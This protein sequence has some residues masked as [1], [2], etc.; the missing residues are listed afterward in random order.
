[1][2]GIWIFSSSYLT[3]EQKRTLTVFI[4]EMH[5]IRIE[6]SNRYDI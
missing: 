6:L 5:K 2:K 3:Y 1:M 4:F